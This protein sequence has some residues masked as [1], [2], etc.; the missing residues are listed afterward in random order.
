MTVARPNR[1]GQ[2]RI[3]YSRCYIA[4]YRGKSYMI[5]KYWI[6]KTV[7]ETGSEVISR[8]AQRLRSCQA[9]VGSDREHGPGEG[10]PG[11]T[12]AANAEGLS[13]WRRENGASIAQTDVYFG[14]SRTTVARYCAIG[15][16][17]VFSQFRS[18]AFRPW[19]CHAVTF[20][21]SSTA[22]PLHGPT[23]GPRRPSSGIEREVY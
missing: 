1:R 17:E 22:K 11:Q 4:C 13:A 9:I 15:R 23:G 12:K 3:C 21:G 14:I 5:E 8:H 6:F 7:G 10:K 20:R 16:W 18:A 19:R 2:G